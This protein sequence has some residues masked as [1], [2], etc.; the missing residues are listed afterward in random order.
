MAVR[1][2]KLMVSS[3]LALAGM[4]APPSCAAAAPGFVT[5]HDSAGTPLRAYVAGPE[6]A[7]AGVLI[8]HDYFGMSTFTMSAAEHL[9]A[10]GYR[11]LAIDLYNGRSAATHEAA[12][13]LLHAFQSQDRGVTDHTLQAGLDA[14]KRPG[15]SL[16]A[17]GFSMGGIEALQASLND[18]AGVQATV[19]VY[20]SGFDRLDPARLA[21]LHGS[22]LVVAGALDDG[23]VQAAVQMLKR[24]AELPRTFEAAVLPG[25]GHAYAQPLFDGGKGYSPEGT[26]ETWR[27]IDDFLARHAP[28]RT[29]R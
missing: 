1:L 5:L 18:P 19:I 11:A 28:A 21:R 23:S 27:L 6:G 8:V 3:A 4:C 15:R 10:M 9:G 22:L 29:G 2:W 20:G 24:T 25:L 12:L 7:R 13:Q 17:S 16:A 26:C 14:L